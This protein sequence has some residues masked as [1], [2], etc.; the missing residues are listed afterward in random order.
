MTYSNFTLETVRKAFQL[1]LVERAGIFTEIEPVE[2]SAHLTTSL[3]KK[4]PIAT[5]INTEKARSEL[6]CSGCPC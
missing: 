5:T 3:A 6:D 2:P 4:V 1:E